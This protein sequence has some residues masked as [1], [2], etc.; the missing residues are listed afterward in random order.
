MLSR[1][2]PTPEL[3]ARVL[4]GFLLK[5][6]AAY[7]YAHLQDPLLARVESRFRD[8]VL[9][10]QK[11]EPVAYITG[12]KEFMGLTL[13]VNREV[14]IPRPETEVLVEAALA[15][16]DEPHPSSQVRVLDVGTGSGAIA[17]SLAF[18]CPRARLTGLDA[19]PKAL[20]VAR[21]NA[22]R[23]A[24][25]HRVSFV[26]GDIFPPRPPSQPYTLLTAN[27]PYIPSGEMEALPS[28]VRDYEPLQALDGGPDGLL[29]YRRLLSPPPGLLA[30]GAIMALEVGEGQARNLVSLAPPGCRLEIKKDYAGIDRVVLLRLPGL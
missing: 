6:D 23:L 27:L 2:S 1:Y 12:E 24:L 15:A 28:S 25:S 21:G 9:R 30:P 8:W 16:L 5:K 14:L 11:G 17:L 7:L 10:R 13:K 29:F 20:E 18:Y 26:Q 22:R 4:L 19:S 3:D